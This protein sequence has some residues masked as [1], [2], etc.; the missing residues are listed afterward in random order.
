MKP[1]YGNKNFDEKRDVVVA[2]LYDPILN[3]FCLR[4]DND[5][6]Y[7]QWVRGGID[8]NELPT[9]AVVREVIEETGFQSAKVIQEIARF[10]VCQFMDHKNLWRLSSCVAFLVEFDSKAINVGRNNYEEYIDYKLIYLPPDSIWDNL[11]TEEYVV[12]L[13][14]RAKEFI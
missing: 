7:T 10:D 5:N 2:V 4:Q 13:F 11:K 14:N 3:L 1:Y 6:D 9:N 8:D 12:D